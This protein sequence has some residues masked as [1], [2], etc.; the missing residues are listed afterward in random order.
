MRCDHTDLLTRECAHCQGHHTIPQHVSAFYPGDRSYG[1]PVPIGEYSGAPFASVRSVKVGP[2]SK[3]RCQVPG[4]ARPSP[5]A[6]VC[7]QCLDE[8]EVALLNIP[9]LA[10]DLVIATTRQNR[11]SGPSRGRTEVPL[12]YET[13]S[14]AAWASLSNAVMSSARIICEHRGLTMPSHEAVSLSRW[15][16]ANLQA[17]GQDVAGGDIAAEIIG[18]VSNGQRVI[19]RPQDRVYIGLCAVCN[20]PMH[21]DLSAFT[22]RC[23]VCTT[24]YDIAATREALFARVRETIATVGEMVALAEFVGVK[25]K[26]KTVEKMIERGRLTRAGQRVDG[27]AT[28]RLGDLLC[29]I[30]ERS[31]AS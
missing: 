6:F 17:V 20:T 25:V 18:S 24:E 31:E 13:R 2:D 5:Q 4:C 8:L 1:Q 19:D 11:F 21:A 14:A 26:R 30:E 23:T 12:P 16:L 28:Y 3:E 15:L 10:E 9:A 7:G 27:V 29:L 22:H